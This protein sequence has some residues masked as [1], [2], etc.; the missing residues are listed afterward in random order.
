[1]KEFRENFLTDSAEKLEL[2]AVKLKNEPVNPEEIRRSALRLLHTI[3]GTA[4]VFGLN[5][6]ASLAHRLEDQ[7]SLQN[8]HNY[9]LKSFSED[10]S[11]LLKSLKT[12][13]FS[14]SERILE[15]QT[16]AF[17]AGNLSA[18]SESIV[19]NL[20]SEL[21]KVLSPREVEVLESELQKGNKLIFARVNLKLSGFGDELRNIRK[22]IGEFGEIIATIS[23]PD[24]VPPDSIGFKILFASSANLADLRGAFKN[25]TLEICEE[26]LPSTSI[27]KDIVDL[28]ISGGNAVA[29][30]LG[31]SV[32]FETSL[33]HIGDSKID[34][35]V[36]FEALTHLIRNSIDHGFESSGRISI[37]A[38]S[39]KNG[40][41]LTFADDGSGIDLG[42]IKA[43]AI[44]SGLIKESAELSI[45]ATLALIFQSEFSTAAEITEIS[46]RGVGLDAVKHSVEKAGGTISVRNG[47]TGGTVFELFLPEIG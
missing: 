9:S 12:T 37:K 8:R 6:T 29:K 20:S 23:V 26:R 21:I 40:V 16:D 44:D 36:L 2:L 25:F 4:R 22:I 3:K 13:D 5:S 42:K 10:I 45:D 35:S 18:N 19:Q 46:G 11:V 14:G 30:S 41:L 39:V 38:D 7:L 17:S 31:K 1:M 33:H 34:I 15:N 32:S 27:L 43:K 24:D 47:E 28:A